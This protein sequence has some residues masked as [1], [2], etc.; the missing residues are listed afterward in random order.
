MGRP[1]RRLAGEAARIGSI[2]S[3]L[4]P[5]TRSPVDLNTAGTSI[6]DVEKSR[7]VIRRSF[8]SAGPPS[9]FWRNLENLGIIGARLSSTK[10]A[11]KKWRGGKISCRA[12]GVAA[13][14]G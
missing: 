11:S 8:V 9:P 10:I 13:P 7:A 1:Q 3:G 2:R 12:I 6:V 14:H 5:S 4:E